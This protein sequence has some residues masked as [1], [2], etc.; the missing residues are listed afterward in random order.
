MNSLEQIDRRLEVIHNLL[1]GFV[2]GVAFRLKRAHASAM[3]RPFVLPDVLVA[4]HHL[5]VFVRKCQQA[6][7]SEVV[8]DVG[9]TRVRAFADTGA[10]PVLRAAIT[11]TVTVTHGVERA[12]AVI[13]P[14]VT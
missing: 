14:E 10:L 13:W 9:N 7:L 3:L 1:S 11:A 6:A 12:I 4:V 2:V 5:P 8:E